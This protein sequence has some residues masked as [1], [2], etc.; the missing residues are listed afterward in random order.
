MNALAILIRAPVLRFMSEPLTNLTASIM[1]AFS[2]YAS[3][4]GNNLALA[5]AVG[6]A[7]F[8]NF[9]VNRYWTYGDID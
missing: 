2:P 8:W 5:L 1:P 3:R 6:I 9:F 7:L 4:I